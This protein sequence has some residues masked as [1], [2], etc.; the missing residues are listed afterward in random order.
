MAAAALSVTPASGSITAKQNFVL[1]EVSDGDATTR[2][3]IKAEL[4]G[5]ET[6][7]SPEFEPSV[8]GDYQWFNVLF[9]AAGIWTLTLY[10]TADDSSL[11]TASVVVV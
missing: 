2:Q 3:R 8:D 6:L 11:A 9:P 5:E 4:E 10:A 7:T 1:V